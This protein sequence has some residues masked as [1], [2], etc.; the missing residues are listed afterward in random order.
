MIIVEHRKNSRNEL[1]LVSKNHG[2]EIDLR[3]SHG[4][5]VLAHDPYSPGEKFS[6]WIQDF[7]HSLLILNVKEEGLEEV[8]LREMGAKSLDR[9]FFLDQG[10]PSVIKSITLKHSV[11]ARISE[12]EKLT[13]TSEFAPS[14]IWIDCFSGNWDFLDQEIE[15]I[16]KLSLRT[17]LVSPELQGRFD[18][19]ESVNLKS[20]LKNHNYSPDAVC[21][22]EPYKWKD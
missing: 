6:D 7:D 17:C 9:Y 16:S 3:L 1:N 8:I 14:W 11:A 12:F 21:T 18:P 15:Q 4:D 22:K 13:W 5:L 20:I 10:L 2:V 19:S